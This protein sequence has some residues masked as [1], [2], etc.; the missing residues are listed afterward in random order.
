ML[1]NS[2][3]AFLGGV[4]VY[5]TQYRGHTPEELAEMAIDKIIYVGKD[6]HPAIIGQAEA[7]KEQIKR[8]ITA[9]MHKAIKCDRDTVAH[10]L[11][12]AGHPELINLLEM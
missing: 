4:K 7:F 1:D 12:Q 6:S 10:K 8:V 11:R 9:Y 2:G 5:T 3:E